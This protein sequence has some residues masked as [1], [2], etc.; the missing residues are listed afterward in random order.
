M[1]YGC[2]FGAPFFARLKMFFDN[3]SVQ[4]Q[5]F[6]FNVL[7]EGFCSGFLRCGDTRRYAHFSGRA[8]FNSATK[9]RRA[10]SL[11]ISRVHTVLFSILVA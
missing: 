11:A 3:I 7:T 2:E 1:L 8:Y 6:N 4:F 5:P 10:K 9:L